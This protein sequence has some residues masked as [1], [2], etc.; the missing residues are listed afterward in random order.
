[1][2]CGCKMEKKLKWI[3]A[4]EI[5]MLALLLVLLAWNPHLKRQEPEVTE[6]QTAF[7]AASAGE[8][9]APAVSSASLPP[10]ATA[11]AREPETGP[12]FQK[13]PEG[14][15]DDALFIGDSRTVGIQTYWP[16]GGASFFCAV[17]AGVQGIYGTY[18]DTGSLSGMSL[19]DVITSR[20]YGKIYVMLGVND[21]YAPIKENLELY[22]ELIAWLREEQPEAIV[23]IEAN[24]RVTD[25]LSNSGSFMTNQNINEFNNLIS[26]LADN[27]T[28]FYLDA[29]PLFSDEK[30]ALDPKL[31]GDG[32][33]LYGQA[34]EDWAQWL[35][36]HVIVLDP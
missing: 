24:L 25:A 18:P 33:H 36:D 8:T 31:T 6:P 21:L 16:E 1:M 22:E 34:Y 13:A 17:G 5:V 14:Y 3:L 26:R 20:K 2:E 30:G 7:Y 19:R 12:M 23:Y 10:E 27:E 11:E 29:N 9:T 32:I 4:A 35:M 15:F 28:I